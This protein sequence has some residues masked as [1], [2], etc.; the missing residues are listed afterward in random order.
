MHRPLLVMRFPMMMLQKSDSAKPFSAASGHP[1]MRRRLELETTIMKSNFL[2]PSITS[3]Y[4]KVALVCYGTLLATSLTIAA[5]PSASAAVTVTATN[6]THA[7]SALFDT[8]AGNLRVVVTNTSVADALVP[9]DILTAIFFDLIGNPTL[10]AISASI[11]GAVLNCTAANS[12][13]APVAGNVG[14]EWAYANSLVGAPQGAHQGISSSGLG[15]FGQANFNGP[16]LQGPTAVAGGQFGITSAGDNPGTGNG[17]LNNDALIQNQVTF[18]LGSLPAGFNVN[19]G[20]SNVFFQ[21][22]TSLAVAVPEPES[23]AMIL[24]GLGLMGF[25]ARRRRGKI[26]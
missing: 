8:V 7:A 1:R 21:Y 10:S 20:V 26:S 13:M 2:A 23:Y 4:N 25:V 19:T 11:S 9:T 16:N 12:C 15:L 5:T 6:G 18:V 17:G 3:A 24:A 14:G 22:G